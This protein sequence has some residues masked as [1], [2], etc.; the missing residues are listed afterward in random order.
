VF[1]VWL[2]D[3][4]AFKNAIQS[5]CTTLFCALNLALDLSRD[6]IIL[7]RRYV[8]RNA[9]RSAWQLSSRRK[10][11]SIVAIE[12]RSSLAGKIKT[13]ELSAARFL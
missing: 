8:V 13:L 9:Q 5:F 1:N 3:M 7:V 2:A 10:E 4:P 12:C 11:D 6:V